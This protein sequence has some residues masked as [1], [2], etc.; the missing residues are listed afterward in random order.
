MSE[1]N[2]NH[3]ILTPLSRRCV[4]KLCRSTCTLTGLSSPAATVANR[5]AA[6][7][8]RRA[9]QPVARPRGEGGAGLY[10]RAAGVARRDP[11]PPR[12]QRR[13]YDRG[14]VGGAR[15]RQARR[16]PPRAGAIRRRAAEAAQGVDRCAGR[17]I[18]IKSR[19]HCRRL[20]R[21]DR[22]GQD[23]HA[24][25]QPGGSPAQGIPPARQG[26]AGEPRGEQG[27]PRADREAAVRFAAF[28]ARIDALGG[29]DFPEVGDDDLRPDLDDVPSFDRP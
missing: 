21:H 1:Q 15:L 25:P 26:G 22:D 7:A 28:W 6:G 27:H 2:L 20:L 9:V 23:L 16:P 19:Y 13:G 17:V 3:R 8:G 5:Q 12:R 4:A 10:R 24:R 18:A 29:S 11:R 14:P